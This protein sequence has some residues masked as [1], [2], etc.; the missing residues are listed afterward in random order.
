[1]K[2]DK[3]NRTQRRRQF[4]SCIFLL[5]TGAS[6]AQQS[7]LSDL[8]IEALANLQVT[9][10]SKKSE[11]LSGAPAA[12]FVLTSEDLQSGGFTT[13][14][15]ALR[16]VPGL[17]VVESTPHAWQVS[18]RGFSDNNNNK[19]LVLVDGR[20]VYTPLFGGVHWDSLDIPLESIDR[21]EIIRGPGGTLWG[22]N[23]VNGVINI[24]TIDSR[25]T[26]GVSVSTSADINQGYTTSVQF[27]GTAGPS[28]SYRLFGKASYFEPFLSRFG[29]ELGSSWNLSRLGARLDWQASAKD[30]LSLEGETYEGRFHGPI[31]FVADSATNLVKGSYVLTRWKHEL[32]KASNIDVL[33]YCDWYTRQG[34]GA[35]MRNTCDLEFQHSYEIS[36]RHSLI[37]GGSFLSTGDDLREDSIPLVPLRRRISLVTGFAQYE[38]TL[39]PD[40][41]RILGGSKIEHNDYSGFEYQPQVRAVWTPNKSTAIWGSVSRSVRTPTRS[42]E[43]AELVIPAGTIN[44]LPAFARFLGNRNLLSERLKAYELGYRYQPL[45][46]A[47]LD[48]ALYYNEYDDLIVQS[49]TVIRVL[50]AMVFFDQA[51]V[52]GPKAQ[53]HGGELSVKWRPV[54]HWALSTG[55]TEL[56][57]S[58]NAADGNSHHLLNMQS[59]IDLPHRGELDSALY[60]YS[61]LPVQPDP[62][63]LQFPPRG[64]PNLNRFDAGLSWHV[65]QW[66]LAVWG[67]N[68]QSEKHVESLDAIVAGVASEV[69][70]S[71]IF[72]LTWQSHPEAALKSNSAV[73]DRLRN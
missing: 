19:M 30:S 57:G 16:S 25:E 65:S 5:L 15:D 18:A 11:S 67:R 58:T 54:P 36:K 14:P 49:P 34:N 66:T 38:L 26:Q 21:I 1:M 64:N 7:D 35:E 9:S 3:H 28:L 22:A 59:R 44:G 46:N 32:S 4:V 2:N 10:A 68:L 20:S 23:A 33:A 6:Y 50:P 17:Y 60:H 31:L 62:L 48:L 47:S 45:P 41:L 43:D 40:R 63:N 53:T 29:D 69:P 12:I 24:V 8:S 61:A 70:R 55:I 72:K 52:N 73:A 37:W 51:R 39:L 56:R 13:L 27:G 42:D 71:I